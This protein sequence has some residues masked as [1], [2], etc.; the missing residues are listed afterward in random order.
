MLSGVTLPVAATAGL[1]PI[2]GLVVVLYL[3]GITMMG[4]WMGRRITGLDDFFMPRKFGKGMMMMHA[5]GTGTASDQAVTVSS[6]TFRTGLSGIWYQ[7]LWLFVTPF[8][9]LIAPIFRRFRAITT[10]DVYELRYDRSVAVLFAIVGIANMCVKI[11][12]MLKGAGALAD[13]GTGGLVD[14]DVA[15]IAVTL[16]FVVYGAA[17]GLGAAIVTDYVQGILTIAFSFM[18]LPFILSEVGGMHGVRETISNEAMMSLVAPGKISWFFV[19]MMSF[20]ALVGIVA[21][22][23]IM[24][25]C[26]AGKTEWEGRLGIVGGNLIK[27][28]CTAAW[29][30]TAIAAVAWYVQS[31]NDPSLLD[32]ESLRRTADGIYGEVAHTFLPGLAPG[33]LG[34][35]LAALLAGVMSSCDSFMISSAA[36]FTE[37]IYKPLRTEVSDKHCIWVGRLASILVVAGGFAFAFWVPSVVNALE[38]WFIIAPMMGLVFWIG[39]FWRRMTV[40]CAWATTVTG[41]VAW[42]V[43]TQPWFINGLGRIPGGQS[44]RLL[45]AEGDK[46]VVYLPWQILFYSLAASAVGIVVS[47]FTRPV[48]P[49]KLNRFYQ[50]SRTP[51]QPG[52]EV[53]QPC[54]L[55]TTTRAVDRPMLIRAGGLEIPMPSRTS[56]IGFMTV[57]LFV[58]GIIG[59]F[60]WIVSSP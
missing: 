59:A 43:S 53:L 46:I 44:L 41:F 49:N 57:W 35:F 20:Q 52:E 56:T 11:G 37:N 27:R 30:L 15:I 1:H 50:L 24:G 4:I 54:T 16:M 13:A 9:W 36:L 6:A 14:A 38:I 32:T 2:D 26:A 12:L 29:S 31:G 21:Q 28:L 51:V 40:A 25:V 34:L 19:V 8:Y 23:F 5:F 47:L 48:S 18:L 17:G 42:W 58:G 60:V 39:L 45:W 55:P 3:I 10:A 33:L 22:P 7:W